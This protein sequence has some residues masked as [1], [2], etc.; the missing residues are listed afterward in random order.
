MALFGRNSKKPER[1]AAYIA[2]E[3][4][5][6]QTKAFCKFVLEYVDGTT[7]GEQK[8]IAEVNDK[9][10]NAERLQ[11]RLQNGELDPQMCTTMGYALTFNQLVEIVTKLDAS[12]PAEEEL[13]AASKQQL[14][15]SLEAGYPPALDLQKRGVL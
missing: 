10:S 12:T 13:I 5:L 2:A 3:R 4:V 14:Q 15:A 7:E 1:T 8:M 11:E 6:D 9:L